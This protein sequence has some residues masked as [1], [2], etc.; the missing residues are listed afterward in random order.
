MT[1]AALVTPEEYGAVGDGVT[2]D[3]NAM[4]AAFVAAGRYD[5][6]SVIH[7]D[8]AKTYRTLRTIRIER[9]ASQITVSGGGTWLSEPTGDGGGYQQSTGL[10]YHAPED[11]ET[12]WPF[13]SATKGATYI[14]C[15]D[16]PDLVVGDYV[17]VMT[18]QVIDFDATGA[19]VG[20]PDSEI[21]RVV[22]VDGSRVHL[23][24][25]LAK[26]YAQEYWATDTE[27]LG[28]STT[29]VVSAY[30]APIG[31]RKIDPLV[32]LHFDGITI[33]HTSAEGP[34]ID[35]TPFVD[36]Q[37]TDVDADC[38]GAFMSIDGWTGSMS[39][40]TIHVRND[41]GWWFTV[42]YSARSIAVSDCVFTSDAV[43]YVH[44]HEGASDISFTD[45]SI[46]NA[47]GEAFDSDYPYVI[48]LRG[49]G[50]DISLTRVSVTNARVS[51]H[52]LRVDGA[53]PDA[54]PGVSGT[55]VD[56]TH[57]GTGSAF[58]NYSP[59]FTVDGVAGSA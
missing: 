3:S 49:R 11:E 46:T 18:G 59:E 28:D 4:E 17:L 34:F 21:N 13:T 6:E 23:S 14:D 47:A 22:S 33:R 51:G 30:P 31:V 38:D 32:G 54:S 26:N 10:H 29:T 15:T 50:Y 36:L 2:D 8:P 7:L 16:T 45:V 37:F 57:S 5:G 1:P 27:G 9:R 52:A 42:A 19:P 40:C 58:L 43:G 24:W 48:G 20:F 53:I 25:P 35:R 39:G 55:A 41:K 56:F 44:I 12:L